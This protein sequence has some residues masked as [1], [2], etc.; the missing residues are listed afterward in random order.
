MKIFR[1][2]WVGGHQELV[3]AADEKSVLKEAGVRGSA[4]AII[5]VVREIPSMSMTEM[6]EKLNLKVTETVFFF[7]GTF[8]KPKL[9][10]GLF[11]AWD[12]D[13]KN[14]RVPTDQADMFM[15]RVRE[16]LAQT[17]TV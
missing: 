17:A 7:R 13:A 2:E 10:E 1:I 4:V 16:H 12:V 14:N 6:A 5:D 9:G 3:G 8:G 15:T 11:E